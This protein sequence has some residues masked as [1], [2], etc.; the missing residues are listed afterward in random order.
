MSQQVPR[1]FGLESVSQNDCMALCMVLRHFNIAQLWCD[2]TPMNSTRLSTL[3]GVYE[4]MCMYTSL[5]LSL[6]IYIYI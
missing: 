2:V 3:V 4:A 6:Y 1:W 5:S